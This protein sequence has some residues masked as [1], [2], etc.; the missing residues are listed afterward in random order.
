MIKFWEE[1]MQENT[2]YLYSWNIKDFKMFKL[3]YS[4]MVYEK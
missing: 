1:Y 4:V 2:W 3:I